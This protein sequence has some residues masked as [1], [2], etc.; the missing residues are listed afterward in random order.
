[1][2]HLH[3]LIRRTNVPLTPEKDMNAAEDFILLLVYA[4]VVAAAKTLK[5]FAKTQSAQELAKLI[6]ENIVC[7]PKAEASGKSSIVR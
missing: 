5:P 7:L 6:A 4:H 3:N 1:M 2:Y